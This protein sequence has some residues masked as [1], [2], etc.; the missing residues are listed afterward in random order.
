MDKVNKQ[1][2]EIIFKQNMEKANGVAK[3]KDRAKAPGVN[4]E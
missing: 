2:R 1:I 3:P 4:K